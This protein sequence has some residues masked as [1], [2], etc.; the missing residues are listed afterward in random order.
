MVGESGAGLVKVR[1]TAKGNIVGID[2]D[3]TILQPSEKEVIEDL[4]LAA[5]TD[6]QTRAS[7]REKEEMAQLTEGLGLPPGMKLPF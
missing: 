4:I 5:L 2:I 7:A 1:S 3:P 6:A